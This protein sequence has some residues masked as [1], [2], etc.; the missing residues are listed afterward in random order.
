MK[1]CLHISSTLIHTEYLV[2]ESGEDP[3][4]PPGGELLL[5]YVECLLQG[6]AP[7]A[8]PE[9]LQPRLVDV[10]QRG[11]AGG[12]PAAQPHPLQPLVADARVVRN[13]QQTKRLKVVLGY[14][15]QVLVN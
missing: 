5:L 4:Q 1:H 3:R 13:L 15:Q 6:A 14:Q 10:L 2:C 7:H 8:G 12:E 11:F 9:D